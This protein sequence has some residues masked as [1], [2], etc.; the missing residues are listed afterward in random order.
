MVIGDGICWVIC[1]GEVLEIKLEYMFGVGC[2]WCI[3]CVG[4]F[5]RVSA[6][7]IRHNI[8]L[9][10]NIFGGEF[11]FLQSYRPAVQLPSSKILSSVK[12]LLQV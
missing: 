7:I 5:E 6:H 1:C 11:K 9:S 3:C 12:E 4:G 2:D 10:L 8:L